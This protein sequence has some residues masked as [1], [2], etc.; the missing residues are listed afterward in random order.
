MRPPKILMTKIG[1][2]GH[3]RGH[4]LVATYLRD[5]GMEVVF[6]GPWKSV[7]EVVAMAT[8]E[9]VDVIGI[10]SLASDHLLVPGLMKALRENGL[11]H[12]EVVVGGTVPDRDEV[13]LKEA[14]VA[15]VFHPGASREEIISSVSALAAKAI[16]ARAE[17]GAL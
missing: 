11:K 14:G 2:D 6:T 4:R 8:E 12:V 16:T 17:G 3:D 9:D 7:P 10:S 15:A 1:L 13:E 5:A